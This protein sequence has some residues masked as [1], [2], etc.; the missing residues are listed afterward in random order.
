MPADVSDRLQRYLED[1]YPGMQVTD[2]QFLASGSES[3]IYTF[4]FH[5]PEGITKP[6]ILRV[7]P[8]DNVNAKLLREVNGLLRLQQVGFPVA[9]IL[10]YE[11]DPAILGK[12]FTIMEKL[13]GRVLWPVLYQVD[14]LQAGHL[15][16]R[17]G[18]LQAQL[19][20]LDWHP[21]TDQADRY[22][23][24]PEALLDEDLTS[25]DR[26]PVRNNNWMDL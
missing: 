9:A 5:P 14:P 1:Y 16:D 2:F 17:F 15:L 13:E 21:F 7:Y 26:D 10:Y 11:T 20:R 23:T 8:G 19:H 24:N 6:L 3:D 25:S 12:P 22:Q 4:T 18:S